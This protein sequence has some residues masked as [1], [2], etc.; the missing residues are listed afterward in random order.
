MF[1]SKTFYFI[2]FII[3]PACIGF[4]INDITTGLNNLMQ[5]DRLRLF[6][7]MIIVIIFSGYTVDYFLQWKNWGKLK[8][9]K[10]IITT[11]RSVYLTDCISTTVI[12]PRK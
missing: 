3:I 6:L 12:P 5:K 7:R 11:V 1:N 2:R 4:L 10:N 8:L 9:K